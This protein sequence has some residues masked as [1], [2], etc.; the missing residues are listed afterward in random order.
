MSKAVILQPQFFPWV[1]VFEQI[2]LADVYLHL[3]DV[4]I[5]QGRSFISRVQIK[6]LGGVEWLT[7]PIQRGEKTICD[8]KI[9]YSQNWRS[10]HL[11]LLKRAYGGAPYWD[12]LQAIVLP[13]Y[14]SDPIYLSELNSRAIQAI[15]GYFR[16]STKFMSSSDFPTATKSSEKL[17]ELLSKLQANI[18]I[19][20]HGAKNY[21]DH[22][23]FERHGIRVEYMLYEKKPY[24]Q[25]NGPFTPFVSILDLIA[26]CGREGA[27]W[28]VSGTT[29]WKDFQNG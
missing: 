7:L 20:G 25:L 28:L 13:I 10:R 17:V 6:S 27:K 19:T 29:Y 9:D 2:K 5:P 4:Q 3:D 18:Y 15:S 26:N 23:L 24:P 12:D 16:L 1:G 21:L 8:V 22:E 14:E 11:H